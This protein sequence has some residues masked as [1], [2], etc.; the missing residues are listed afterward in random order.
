[1]VPFVLFF[2]AYNKLCFNWEY[3]FSYRLAK[4]LYY[5]GFHAVN[6]NQL[7]SS[8]TQQ[9]QVKEAAQK[10]RAI[11]FKMFIRVYRQ[12]IQN[13]CLQKLPTK[14][15]T[16]TKKEK[17]ATQQN[18]LSFTFTKTVIMNAFGVAVWLHT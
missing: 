3:E 7:L 6:S 14:T 1:M 16:F 17:K 4:N 9:L 18:K 10:Q 12:H 8:K 2:S 5:T 15:I 11:Q 13:S